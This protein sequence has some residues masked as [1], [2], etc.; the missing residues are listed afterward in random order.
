MKRICRKGVS[1]FYGLFGFEQLI[2]PENIPIFVRFY[3][4]I[5]KDL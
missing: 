4:C 3:N 1:F 5:I 2:V